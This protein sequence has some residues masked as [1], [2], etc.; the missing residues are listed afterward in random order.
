MMLRIIHGRLKPGTWNAYERA[1]KEAMTKTGKIPGLR[2]RW[3]SHA[4]DDPDAGY[5][6]SVWESEEAMRTY[7]KG[8]ILKKIILPSLEPFFTGEYTTTS[9]EVRFVEEFE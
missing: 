1:Y 8:E 4:V 7:E 5:T 6:V 2:A 9:C 3:L